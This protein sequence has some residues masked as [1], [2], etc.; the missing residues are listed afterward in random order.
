MKKA[1]KTMK[2]I[3]EL[4]GM[5]KSS[6]QDQTVWTLLGRRCLKI[7]ESKALSEE[8]YK[9]GIDSDIIISE[10]CQ[11]MLNQVDKGRAFETESH[12]R[13]Y[14]FIILK[15]SYND[16][17]RKAKS[18]YNT[19]N[20]LSVSIEDILNNYVSNDYQADVTPELSIETD[21]AL[22]RVRDHL[23]ETLSRL[24]KHL[25]SETFRIFA[26]RTIEG[27]SSIEVARKYG[28]SPNTVDQICSRVR[29]YIKK[30]GPHLNPA[31]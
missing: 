21:K 19:P 7:A 18:N 2:S 22:S 1:P 14:L 13:S 31:A 20:W 29:K 27:L 3:Q 12:F 25:S 16:A 4:L 28:I 10:T 24:K 6:P 5:V 23:D 9:T 26:D 17:W 8:Y 15:N 11:K 30:P